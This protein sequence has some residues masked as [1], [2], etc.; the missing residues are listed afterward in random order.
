MSLVASILPFAIGA[1]TNPA[2]LAIELL[3]LSGAH[4][5]KVRTWAY[6]FGFVVALLIFTAV[7]FLLLGRMSDAGSGHPSTTSRIISAVIAVALLAMGIKTLIPKK[8]TKKPS[9]LAARIANAKTPAFFGIGLLAM[10]TDASSMI[11]LLPALHE[12][13]LADDAVGIK[14]LATAVLLLVM[15]LPLTLPVLAVTVLGHRADSV[16][17]KINGFVSRHQSTINGIVII[18]IALL[19]GYKAL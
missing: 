12:I 7:A 3:I 15:L 5:A 17:A 2:A 4:R 1:A 19:V 14:T 9:K 16:L 10:I 8:G 11:L 18:V 6:L 13:S